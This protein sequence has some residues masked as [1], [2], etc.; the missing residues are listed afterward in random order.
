MRFHNRFRIAGG[1]KNMKVS[2]QV[3]GIR[4]DPWAAKHSLL[5]EQ[6]KKDSGR[7]YYL[8]PELHNQSEEKGLMRLR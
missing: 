3:T 7:G 1:A 6:E 5:V 8:H 2:W 4:K